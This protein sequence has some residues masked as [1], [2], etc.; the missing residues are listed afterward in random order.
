MPLQ[1]SLSLRTSYWFL[2]LFNYKIL[3]LFFF[4]PLFIVI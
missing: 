3:F 4:F 1:R 2:F